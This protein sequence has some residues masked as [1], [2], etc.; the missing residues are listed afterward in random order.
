M[1]ASK[2][3]ISIKANKLEFNHK[4]Q[5][6]FPKWMANSAIVAYMVVVVMMLIVFNK[7]VMALHYWILSCLGVF[8]FFYFSNKLSHDWS[9]YSSKLF[10]KQIF[11]VTVILRF[12]WIIFFS[13]F[14]YWLWN[15]P[16]EQP[17]GVSMDSY[18]YYDTAVWMSTLIDDGKF[19]SVI[20]EM[21]QDG[22]VSD[23][24]YPI[25]LAILSQI[26]LGSIVWT[27][28]PNC[29]FEAVVC[30]MVYRIGRRHFGE[31]VGRLGAIFTMLMPLTFMYTGITMKES[32]MIML[33]MLAVNQLDQ[34]IQGEKKG[35]W[36]VVLGLALVA[37]IAFFRTSLCL[38][39][40]A[41]FLLG[42][43]LSESKRSKWVNR[44][45]IFLLVIVVGLLFAG[46]ALNMQMSEVK[47]SLEMSEG[48]FENRS[49]GNALVQNMSKAMFAPLIFSVP[50]PTMVEIP[51]QTWQQLCAGGNFIKNV[52]SFFVIILFFMLLFQRKWRAHTFPIAVLCG[53]LI[54]LTMS[55]FAHSGRF[56]EPAVPLELMFA[57]AGLYLYPIE[58]K[59]VWK[60][61]LVFE[62]VVI[63]GWNWFKLKGRGLI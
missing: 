42:L 12:V 18:A 54:A 1:I 45:F 6:W 51:G 19:W 63:I 57:A 47:S 7:Q 38:V 34:I 52:L 59:K 62:L 11:F 28:I 56:H 26:G 60:P 36:Q 61:I 3:K 44:L 31:N 22:G 37:S 16:W 55:S 8:L 32:I 43:I 21:A 10:E 14:T 25:W 46:D 53:Y 23:L 5:F 24:G 27:R 33:M 13:Q 20:V 58:C 48:N 17:D 39:M 15:T 9:V 29:I 35:L 49:R 30:I 50:F 2:K 4:Q 40:L 41:A